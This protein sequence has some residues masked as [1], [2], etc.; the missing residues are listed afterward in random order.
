MY[1]HSYF[2]SNCNE[3]NDTLLKRHKTDISYTIYPF[4]LHNKW[5]IDFSQ[6]TGVQIE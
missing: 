2:I 3:S 6:D 4:K 5:R 1:K